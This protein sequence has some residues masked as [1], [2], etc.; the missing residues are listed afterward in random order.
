MDYIIDL[1]GYICPEFEFLPKEIAVVSLMRHSASSWIL[2]PPNHYHT[3]EP[4]VKKCIDLYSLKVHGI[5]W[6]EG[7]VP[8]EDLCI[9]IKN[10]MLSANNIYTFVDSRSKVEFLEWTLGRNVLNLCDFLCSSSSELSREFGFKAACLHHMLKSETKVHREYHCALNNCHLYKKWIIKVARDYSGSPDAPDSGTISRA[11]GHY[12]RENIEDN[13]VE[14]MS[15]V[16]TE[17]DV[18]DDDDDD[19]AEDDNTSAA[20]SAPPPAYD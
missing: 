11:L 5:R 12:L 8:G 18:D 2:S 19:D 16:S 17:D 7:S 15:A 20:G 6:S 14:N 13:L 9:E 1:Q 4:D 3:Y 10:M